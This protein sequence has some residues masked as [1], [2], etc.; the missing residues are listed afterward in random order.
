[1]VANLRVS[2][3]I[4][5]IRRLPRGTGRKRDTFQRIRKIRRWSHHGRKSSEFLQN[6]KNSK[7]G[8]S[9]HRQKTRCIPK[10]SQNSAQNSKNS[11]VGRSQQQKMRYIP[12]NSKNSKIGAPWAQIFGFLEEFEEFEDWRGAPAENATQSKEFGKFEDGGT[13]AA[14]LRIA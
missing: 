5:R 14:I 3:R 8:A 13:M 7:D 10:N 9:Q 1:M 12:K 6:S 2:R 11:K 4:R